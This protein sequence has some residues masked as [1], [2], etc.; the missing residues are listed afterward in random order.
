MAEPYR[1]LIE[2][3]SGAE[4]F[5][6]FET[7]ERAYSFA[8]AR[9]K[10]ARALKIRAVHCAPTPWFDRDPGMSGSRLTKG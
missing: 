10:D 2:F 6:D 1:V 9:C 4:T 7:Q 5:A 3:E 8:A